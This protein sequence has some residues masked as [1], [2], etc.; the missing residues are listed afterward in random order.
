MINLLSNTQPKVAFIG[1]G[2]MGG[3]ILRGLVKQGYPLPSLMA[4][5]RDEIKLQ[6]LAK[7]TGIS[8]TTDNLQAV[9]WADLVVLGVKPQ[10]MQA[11]CASLAASVQ[12]KKP[13]LLSIAAGLTTATLLDWLGGDLPLVRSMPN[14]P[15]LLGAGVAGLYAT[16]SVSTQQRAW[17]EAISTAVG[18]AHWVTE[19]AQLNAVT[20]ISGSGPAY[21]FLFTEALAAAGEKLG[22]TP[23]LALQLAKSTAAGAGKMLAESTDSPAELR[24]KVTSPGGTTEQA[25]QTFA[26]KGLP[27]LVEAA[28]Q[29]AAKRAVELAT[30]LK[31]SKI[32]SAN[33]E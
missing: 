26:N 21:Y 18:T 25:I 2:N 5:G 3:A 29:A 1:A 7:E 11:V 19:E 8:V 30:A 14:T 27:E 15:S 9:A 6:Q 16:A 13:L 20:A 33:V 32:S 10:M 12:Q 22:L 23:E 24:R 31:N 28:T 4:T 17:V